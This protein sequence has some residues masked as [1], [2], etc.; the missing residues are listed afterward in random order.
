MTGSSVEDSHASANS[1]TCY[2]SARTRRGSP[3]RFPPRR[4]E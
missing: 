3:T 4:I 2:K 1:R